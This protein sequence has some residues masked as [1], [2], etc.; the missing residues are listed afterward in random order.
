M[1]NETN[2][3]AVHEL[4]VAYVDACWNTKRRCSSNT[5]RTCS[6]IP[7][8]DAGNSWSS[9]TLKPCFAAAQ[10]A[11]LPS[12]ERHRAAIRAVSSDIPSSVTRILG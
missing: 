6:P 11:Q 4:A 12:A 2:S 1:A 7:P 5:T 10:Q 8:F 9:C 3:C